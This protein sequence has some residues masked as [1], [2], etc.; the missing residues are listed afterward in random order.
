LV[1]AAT[2]AVVWVRRVS[3][4]AIDWQQVRD[5]DP[6]VLIIAPAVST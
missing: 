5:A 3:I 1:D 2:A 4:P 6:D